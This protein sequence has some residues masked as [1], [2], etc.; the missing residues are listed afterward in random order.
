M[1]CSILTRPLPWASQTRHLSLPEPAASWVLSLQTWIKWE[2]TFQG[3]LPI[4]RVE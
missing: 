4:F 2:N 3:P 1:L